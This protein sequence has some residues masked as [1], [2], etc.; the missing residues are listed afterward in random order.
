MGPAMGL[1]EGQGRAASRFGEMSE[2]EP[3][4]SRKR[5]WGGTER[6]GEGETT[7][8]DSRE[9]ESSRVLQN[10]W[11]RLHGTPA[12]STPVSKFPRLKLLPPRGYSQT[13]I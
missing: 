11:T 2:E 9:P 5:G 13:E 10:P 7:K 4:Q 8:R 12:T 6:A 3:G 1:L